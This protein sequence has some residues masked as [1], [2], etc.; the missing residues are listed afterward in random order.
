M[1]YVTKTEKP[2]HNQK[3]EGLGFLRYYH[4]VGDSQGVS[5]KG[6]KDLNTSITQTFGLILRLLLLVSAKQNR[7]DSM[8][9]NSV[10]FGVEHRKPNQL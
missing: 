8:A 10:S 7:N 5:M 6:E 1:I 2:M 3:I 4:I 9:A